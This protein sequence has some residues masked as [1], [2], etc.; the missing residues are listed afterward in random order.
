MTFV[1]KLLLGIFF[2]SIAT[3]VFVAEFGNLHESSLA[4]I[5]GLMIGVSFWSLVIKLLIDRPIPVRFDD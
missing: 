2:L 3:I 1:T 4:K 5:A